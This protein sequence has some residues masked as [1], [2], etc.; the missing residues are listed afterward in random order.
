VAS[1]AQQARWRAKLPAQGRCSSCGRPKLNGCRRCSRCLAK[2]LEKR[3]PWA[4]HDVA[5]HALMLEA[6]H[7]P[8]ARCA[9]SGLS[10]GQLTAIGDQ[11]T[12]DR[13]DSGRG[14]VVGNL[15]LLSRKLNRAKWREA[16]PPQWEVERLLALHRGELLNDFG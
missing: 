5:A 7:D 8:E 12:V 16:R 14:Y 1:A 2:D 13:L 15:Q 6:S 11:L 9:A 10:G 4:E 3:L